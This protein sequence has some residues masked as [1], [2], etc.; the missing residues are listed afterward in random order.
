[1]AGTIVPT[2]SVLG[3]GDTKETSNR[4]FRDLLSAWVEHM[5]LNGAAQIEETAIAVAL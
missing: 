5:L 3:R 1:M 2:E 4:N